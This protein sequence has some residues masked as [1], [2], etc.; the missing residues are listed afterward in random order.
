M[1]RMF[2]LFLSALLLTGL[3]ASA[4]A[5]GEATVT[6]TIT[7]GHETD[8]R[9]RGR[10]VVLIGNALGVTPEIFRD[11]F[12]HVKPAAAGTRPEP[13]Q[14]Q[15]N[16]A[17]LL[18]ALGR[19]GVT[20]DELD[21]VSNYYRYRPESGRLWPVKSATAQAVIKDGAVV[22]ITITDG[23]AGYSSV[24]E[25]AV[26]GHPDIRFKATVGYGREL[27]SNGSV[28]AIVVAGR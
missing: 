4:Q 20:N 28:A 11:A 2:P 7:G 18:D 13:A 24:P 25:V 26:P 15:R 8:P 23:G 16:K 6:L 19:Y 3:L 1:K 10:P 12:S 5:A 9:D 17:A 21:R 14:V 27:K 22:S